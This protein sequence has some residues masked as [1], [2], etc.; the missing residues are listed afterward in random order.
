LNHFFRKIILL[1]IF[2]KVI[3]KVLTKL[4][5]LFFQN[6]VCVGENGLRKRH[7]TSGQ[8]FGFGPRAT[9][10]CFDGACF[11]D[12]RI[13]LMLLE[14]CECCFAGTAPL[15][16]PE[17]RRPSAPKVWRGDLR[18]RRCEGAKRA[19]RRVRSGS[20]LK[21]VRAGGLGSTLRPRQSHGPVRRRRR[22]ESG[23]PW[24]RRD[25]AMTRGC[26]RHVKG[27]RTLQRQDAQ[28]VKVAW[29]CEDTLEACTTWGVTFMPL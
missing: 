7:A 15:V 18:C 10:G 20:W 6:I 5:N 16:D 3:R 28:R 27:R 14:F 24:L 25:G 26:S 4:F 23:G 12:S 13:T 29:P 11:G 19:T 1:V 17:W 8:V 2:L 21:A 9:L 22:G